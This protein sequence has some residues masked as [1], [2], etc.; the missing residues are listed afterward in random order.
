MDPL[1][2]LKM[3]S[4]GCMLDFFFVKAEIQFCE[5]LLSVTPPETHMRGHICSNKGDAE[6]EGCRSETSCLSHLSI[7]F[8]ETTFI[9]GKTV[10]GA[11]C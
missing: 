6:K 4:F 9:H 1:I 8:P 2:L 3:P 7:R 10:I 11:F 5:D